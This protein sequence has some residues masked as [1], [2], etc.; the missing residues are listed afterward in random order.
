MSRLSD[1]SKLK[2][3][4]DNVYADQVYIAPGAL[5]RLPKYNAIPLDE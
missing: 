4:S 1:Y 3:A 5:E 2:A